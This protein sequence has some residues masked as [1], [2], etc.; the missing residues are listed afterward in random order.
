MEF[1]I[2]ESEI[3]EGQGIKSSKPKKESSYS[4]L[5]LFEQAKLN[6]KC[7]IDEKD[8]PRKQE[9]DYSKV[10][11][12]K[13]EYDNSKSNEDIVFKEYKKLSEE[14]INIY[15]ILTDS[16]IFNSIIFFIKELN[17]C[18]RLSILKYNL[19]DIEELSFIYWF[20]FLLKILTP[21]NP[22]K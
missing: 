9:F 19:F 14:M 2:L 16:K 12:K 5:T 4:H 21:L 22:L 3:I 17:I 15:S 18:K 10:I 1:E 8:V 13:I 11:E 7:E 20:V 6:A